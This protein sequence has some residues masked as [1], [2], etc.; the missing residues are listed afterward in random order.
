M[1]IETQR[2]TWAQASG[3]TIDAGLRQYML[4]VYN[5]MASGLALTGIIAAVVAGTPAIN[6]LFFQFG[7]QGMTLTG[8]GWLVTIS[9]IVL[10]MA[11]SFGITK[12]RAN[13]AQMLLLL[14]S[15]LMGISLS[16]IFLVYT[17]ES[18]I[19]VF[20]ITS[21]S[22]AGLSFYGY[23]TKRNLSVFGTFLIMGL[24]GLVITSIVSMFIVSSAL[25]FVISVAGVGI[26]AGL[27]AWDTQKIKEMYWETD[28]TETTSKKAVIGALTIYLDFINLFIMLLRLVGNRRE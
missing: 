5:Y 17:G 28:D 6:Q 1:T 14:Y 23:T 19:R 25:Q 21:A 4:R 9:P 13:T 20:F 8:L 11:I 12:M 2:S 7:I 24:W 16:S 3:A 22:F 27:T 26:F 10:V 15:G 18:V